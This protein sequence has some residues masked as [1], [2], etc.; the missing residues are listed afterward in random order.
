[1]QAHRIIID[2]PI[3]DFGQ[4]LAISQEDSRH[5]IKV[6]RLDIGAIVTVLQ[7]NSGKE[8]QAVLCSLGPPAKLKISNLISQTANTSRLGTFIFGLCKGDKNDFV[9]EKACELGARKIIL[10]QT[11]HSVARVK[12]TEAQ[13]KLERWNKIIQSAS[14]QSGNI[15]S[16]E[17]KLI[18]SEAELPDQI[19]ESSSSDNLNILCSLSPSAIPLRDLPSPKRL[20]NLAVGPEGDF[21]Q[22]EERALVDLGFKLGTLG[23]L[24]LRSETAA[25]AALAAPGLI[26]GT[27]QNSG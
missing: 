18:F 16:P 22:Q 23:K 27:L 5:L 6:L 8:Y 1:M 19:R 7:K 21:T 20:V 10:W 3:T 13:H 17:V 25:I 2:A 9:C 26:W 11:T 12:A 4:E 24:V 14:K 15:Y